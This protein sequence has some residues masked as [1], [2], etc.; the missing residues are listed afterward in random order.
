MKT[1]EYLNFLKKIRNIKKDRIDFIIQKIGLSTVVNKKIAHLSKGFRQRIGIAQ[2]IV[3]DPSVIILD[4][5]TNGLDPNQII[6]IRKLITDISKDKTVIISTHL[7]QEIEN[8]C[9]NIIIINN[10]RII[11]TQTKNQI[12]QKYKSIEDYFY[13]MTN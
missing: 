6:E 11:D 5:P 3:H 12:L 8:M 13:K 9:K 2:A 1:Y 10:G 7:I 4:E